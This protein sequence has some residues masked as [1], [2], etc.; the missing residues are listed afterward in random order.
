M[1]ASLKNIVRK[2]SNS[3]SSA[4]ALLFV[5]KWNP[6]YL[7]LLLSGII[8]FQAFFP[9]SSLL[10]LAL[11]LALKKDGEPSLTCIPKR[12][13]DFILHYLLL[14]Q[15][16][17]SKRPSSASSFSQKRHPY[18]LFQYHKNFQLKSRLKGAALCLLQTQFAKKP[19]NPE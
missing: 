2:F 9:H 8:T 6:F 19:K 7:S 16:K 1:G 4:I 13:L 3:T 10:F 11:P 18:F 12:N 17:N 14:Q 15:I 5:R